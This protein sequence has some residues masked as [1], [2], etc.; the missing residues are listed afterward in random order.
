MDGRNL[1]AMLLKKGLAMAIVVPPNVSF[2]DCY[3]KLDTQSR[4][5]ASKNDGSIWTH[6]FF[7]YKEANEINNNMTGFNLIKG[8]V[9]RVGRSR[10]S[11][12]L[13]L[14]PKFTI[15]IKRKDFKY[16]K[17]IKLENLNKRQLKNKILYLRGWV[18][19]WK[20]ELYIH[21]RHPRMIE[22]LNL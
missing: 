10:N 1:G 19:Q 12:W 16:F 3:F 17:N 20:K 5:Y 8:K 18:Y 21:L 6:R 4:E 9:I 15:R 2:S 11:V 22:G 7:K 13:Q 14:A